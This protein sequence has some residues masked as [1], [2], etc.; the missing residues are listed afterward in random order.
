MIISRMLLPVHKPRNVPSLFLQQLI[1]LS[2]YWYWEF[3]P[4]VTSHLFLGSRSPFF[5]LGFLYLQCRNIQLP[6]LLFIEKLLECCLLLSDSFFF[7]LFQFY[8]Q[9]ITIAFQLLKSYAAIALA[10]NSEQNDLQ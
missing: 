8:H 5:L 1:H 2:L 9:K 10:E 6:L 4:A 7:F 3:W